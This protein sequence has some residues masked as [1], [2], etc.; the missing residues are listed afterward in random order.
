MNIMAK[1]KKAAEVNDTN[2]NAETTTSKRAKKAALGAADS[3]VATAS[4][5]KPRKRVSAR[6]ATLPGDTKPPRKRAAKAEPKAADNE[7]T[8]AVAAELPVATDAVNDAPAKPTVHEEPAPQIITVAAE[9]SVTVSAKE[10]EQAR[11]AAED[12]RKA[13]DKPLMGEWHGVRWERQLY[14]GAAVKVLLRTRDKVTAKEMAQVIPESVMPYR[15]LCWVLDDLHKAAQAPENKLAK[16]AR[17]TYTS[18]AA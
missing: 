6:T 4:E 3:T 18:A 11:K 15:E 14:V 1:T 5:P 2:Q 16:I 13:P 10:V 9:K 7:T 12:A 17:A 8:L